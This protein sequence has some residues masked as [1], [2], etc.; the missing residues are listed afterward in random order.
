MDTTLKMTKVQKVGDKLTVLR[1]QGSSF[2]LEVKFL[3]SV[4]ET[5]GH[6]KSRGHCHERVNLKVT[7]KL[8]PHSS[9]LTGR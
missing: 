9:L 2:S 3:F 5:R 6:R 1:I 4:T 8:F 7:V